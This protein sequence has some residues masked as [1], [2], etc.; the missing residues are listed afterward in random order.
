MRLAA[1]TSRRAWSA[2]S[3]SA[4][5]RRGGRASP[6]GSRPCGRRRRRRSRRGAGAARR[7]RRGHLVDETAPYRFVWN[8]S[9]IGRSNATVAAQWITSMPP[10]RL[11]GGE[12]AVDDVHA[13]VEHLL[14]GVGPDAVV[15]RGERGRHEGLDRWRPLSRAG[16]ARAGSGSS[17]KSPRKR[18]NT[19]WPRKPV[20]PVT[21]TFRSASLRTIELERAPRG[22]PAVVYH[23][24]DYAPLPVGRQ[25]CDRSTVPPPRRGPYALV[26]TT[27]V[28]QPPPG[29]RCSSGPAGG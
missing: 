5:H 23:V 13:L 14:H 27:R 17:G 19:A 8:P 2:R 22:E 1:S 7:W 24:A 28:E 18:S 25:P 12:V 9:S 20:T 15:E 26:M 11:L 16:V 10:G 21:R 4:S 29:G 3:A 6:R